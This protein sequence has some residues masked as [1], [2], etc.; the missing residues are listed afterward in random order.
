[1]TALEAWLNAP[2]AHKRLSSCK[3]KLAE[4][5]RRGSHQWTA[6][7]QTLALSWALHALSR[8]DEALTLVAETYDAAGADRDGNIVDALSA[9]GLA[10]GAFFARAHGDEIS[11]GSLADR[12]RRRVKK[13][14]A[15]N[16]LE[17]LQGAIDRSLTQDFTWAFSSL[18]DALGY[19]ALHVAQGTGGADEALRRGVEQ[20]ARRLGA[21]ASSEAKVAAKT[22]VAWVARGLPASLRGA[23]ATERAPGLASLFSRLADLIEGVGLWK[24]KTLDALVAV[25][26][27]LYVNGRHPECVAAVKLLC[28]PQ[29]SKVSG[30]ATAR[31]NGGLVELL[32][33]RALGDEAAATRAARALGH[34][35]FGSERGSRE[36]L[37]IWREIV[38]GYH[39]S[40]EK[41]SRTK[42]PTIDA[43]IEAC[44]LVTGCAGAEHNAVGASGERARALRET[45]IELRLRDWLSSQPA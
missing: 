39:A 22:S 15:G 34:T 32:A 1:M 38:D 8:H 18:G 28:S 19:L 17:A 25:A 9:A 3:R 23:A 11:A 37:R 44:A 42:T 20:L 2:E 45:V 4:E 10:S 31:W 13:R 5:R 12:A 35:S 26:V 40:W 21:I 24:S 7:T 41:L 6:L 29:S 14:G 30:A 43:L 27:A 16:T 33:L 36:D